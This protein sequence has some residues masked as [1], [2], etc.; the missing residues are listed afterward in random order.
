VRRRTFS[1]L[2]GAAAAAPAQEKLNDPI[3]EAMRAELTRSLRLSLAGE[4]PYYI[5]YGLDQGANFTCSATLGGLLLSRRSNYRVPRVQVRVGSYEFDNTNCVYT[6]MVRGA[7]FD[8]ENWPLEANVDQ[9]RQD[10]WLATDRSYKAAV[11]TLSLKRAAIKNINQAEKL[12]DFAR[13]TPV[14]KVLPVPTVRV[15]EKRANE[16]VRAFS[17]LLAGYPKILDSRVEYEEGVSSSYFGDSEGTFYR[18]P[19]NMVTLRVRAEALADDGS[20]LRDYLTFHA[21]SPAGLPAD[22]EI[23]QAIHTMAARLTALCAAPLGEAYNGPVLFEGEAAAQLLAQMLGGNLSPVRSP[24]SEPGRPVNLPPSDFEGRLGARVMP[25]FLDI[26]DDPFARDKQGRPLFGYYPVDMEGVVP[27]PLPIVSKGVLK[28]FLLTRQPVRGF[29]GSNG[30]ARLPGGFGASTALPSNL[31]VTATETVPPAALKAKLLDAVRQRNKPYGLIVRKIDFPSSAS[32]GELR[33][34][35]ASLQAGGGGSRPVSLPLAVYRI[36]PDGREEP[37]RGM[38]FRGLTVRAL[39]D[40][41]AA[42]SESYSLNLLLNS[43][44]LALMG[45]GGFVTGVS[46][47]TPSLLFDELDLDR[48][49]EERPSAPLVPPPPLEGED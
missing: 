44:P 27:Q 37:V 23:G 30:R 32:V 6:G 17:A 46:V 26:T 14:V 7:R 8:N 33:R 39:R 10:L 28:N 43:Y 20:P 2:L 38:R 34:L 35:A 11:E 12:N 49:Q 18:F 21:F 48:P 16:R 3:L 29:E 24:I 25:E 36:Y 47:V 9:I 45:A 13:Q 42:S 5:Q 4:T 41:V 31:L 22:T 19:E 15:D 1:L 40:I